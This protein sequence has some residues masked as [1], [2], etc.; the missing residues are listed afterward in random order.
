MHLYLG[1]LPTLQFVECAWLFVALHDD[2]IS[3]QDEAYLDQFFKL[4][5]TAN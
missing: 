1:R 3:E 4:L 2:G 5:K